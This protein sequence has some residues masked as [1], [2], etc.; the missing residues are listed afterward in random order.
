[1]MALIK[2]E[3]HVKMGEKTAIYKPRRK[4]EEETILPKP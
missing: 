3:N 4:T 1:M 2:R